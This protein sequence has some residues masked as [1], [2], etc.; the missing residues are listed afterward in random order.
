MIFRACAAIIIVLAPQ[1]ASAQTTFGDYD[2]GQWFSA[3]RRTSAQA[4]VMG[5]LSGMNQAYAGTSKEILHKVNS[6][7]QLILWI[8]NYCKVNPL[9]N[10][11]DAAIALH[12]ELARK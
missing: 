10:V 6:A 12:A 8:D 3:N 7:D 4:W 2:C 1:I 5:Y 9:K 11:S